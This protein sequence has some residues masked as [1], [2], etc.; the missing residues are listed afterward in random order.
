MLAGFYL[1]IYFWVLLLE[2]EI[3][4]KRAAL[5]RQVGGLCADRLQFLPCTK[6]IAVN[7]VAM[8]SDENFKI[9]H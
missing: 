6:Y 7:C 8:N 4:G 5:G 2:E 3:G 9:N 1:F